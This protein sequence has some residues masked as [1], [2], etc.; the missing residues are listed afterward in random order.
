MLMSGF[1]TSEREPLAHRF[2]DRHAPL[3]HVETL[4]RLWVAPC[5]FDA[6]HGVN[7]RLAVSPS[8]HD[9][10]GKE[11]DRIRRRIRPDAWDGPGRR[12][13][14]SFDAKRAPR[15][16]RRG[17]IRPRSRRQRLGCALS[18]GSRFPCA[19]PRPGPLESVDPACSPRRL[20]VAVASS[21]AGASSRTRA[22][23]RALEI[24]GSWSLGPG[25]AALGE[26]LV[27]MPTDVRGP[28]ITTNFDPLIEVSVRQAGGSP[29]SQHF[30]QDGTLVAS[31]D[32]GTIDIA[33]VHGFWRRGDTL[34][35]IHQ[36]TA[37]RHQL[38]GS[39]RELLR[40]HVVVVMGY[41]G[42]EDAFSNSLSGES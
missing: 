40:G 11:A 28:V 37:P 34:H 4:L 38:D 22:S 8:I 27:G 30:D 26:L 21:S 1:A 10:P 23:L 18:A 25:V 15:R 41:G 12:A 17:E 29:V 5:W 6:I 19:E 20:Y 33:H 14:G 32:D 24:E 16:E 35:T 2:A 9:Q 36:L 7:R 13:T 42:W 39:L 3:G 31:D